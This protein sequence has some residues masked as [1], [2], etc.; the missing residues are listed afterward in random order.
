MFYSLVER[1]SSARSVPE[2]VP[3]PHWL[4]LTTA[5]ALRKAMGR[6]LADGGDRDAAFAEAMAIV[7]AHHPALPMPIIRNAIEDLLRVV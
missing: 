3:L 4:A 2:E 6:C 7:L 5:V 1:A